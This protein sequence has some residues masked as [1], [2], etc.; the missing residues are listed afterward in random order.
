MASR[1]VPR[2]ML[3][4][5]AMLLAAGV[6]LGA[7]LSDDSSVR[8]HSIRIEPR[9]SIPLRLKMY[10]PTRRDWPTPVVLICPAL[11]VPPEIFHTLAMEIATA[12]MI[13]TVVDFFGQKPD[14]SRQ[15]L[16]TSAMA[17]ASTDLEAAVAFVRSLPKGDPSRVGVVGH[18]FG[19]TVALDVAM[20]DP[21]LRATVMIGM[22]GEF[23][24]TQP[25]NVLLIAGLYDE[26]HPQS[27]LLGSLASGTGVKNASPNTL[28][29]TFG[30][31]TARRLIEIPAVSHAAEV[32]YPQLIG[33]VV[34]WFA[35]AFGDPQIRWERPYSLRASAQW[36]AL[37]VSLIVLTLLLYYSER[38]LA[39]PAGSGG[40]GLRPWLSFRLLAVLAALGAYTWSISCF[41]M[42]LPCAGLLFCALSCMSAGWALR[43]WRARELGRETLQPP[44]ALWL[45]LNTSALYLAYCVTLVGNSFLNYVKDPWAAAWIPLFP[46]INGFY[47]MVYIVQRVLV[48]LERHWGLGALQVLGALLCTAEIVRPGTILGLPDAPVEKLRSRLSQARKS[49][50]GGRRSVIILAILLIILALL[51]WRRLQEGLLTSATLYAASGVVLRVMLPV[52]ILFILIRR[53]RI[54]ARVMWAMNGDAQRQKNARCD[55]SGG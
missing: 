33:E 34:R 13:A 9:G 30:D 15:S 38:T 35:N 40:E 2:F 28:Y 12:G 7:S 20:R 27:E 41:S 52:I 6:I 51:T 16:S 53:T 19:A 50:A 39:A 11:N 18:S 22:S 24:T 3:W 55:P 1:W 43:H 37:L 5:L 46:F 49:E 4:A 45:V 44:V 23:S 14:E 29:G 26:L 42:N 47:G 31:G 36:G 25:A 17:A 54:F 8:I 48:P 21:T 32:L 10:L